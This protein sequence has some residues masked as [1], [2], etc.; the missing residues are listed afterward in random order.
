MQGTVPAPL[1]ASVRLIL[2]S[3]LLVIV[4][5]TVKMNAIHSKVDTK[6]LRFGP[7]KCFKLHIGNKS[8]STC[9]TLKIHDKVMAT[10]NK[11]NYFGD[12]LSNDGKINANIQSRHDKG[13]GYVNQIL[14]LLKEIYLAFIISTS[15]CYSELPCL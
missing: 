13:I 8:L 15:P 14:S 6:Q 12:V 10:V 3:L 5:M 9:P 2:L 11:E 1:K 7:S 4:K